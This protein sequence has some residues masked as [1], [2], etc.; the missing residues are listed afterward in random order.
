MAYQLK[1]E[2][3]ILIILDGWG[4][5][6]RYHGN[7]IKQAYTPNIDLLWHSYPTS[8]L[9]AS[10]QHVGL[11]DNQMGN[12]EVGHTT[13]GAGRTINQELVRINK[14]I[15]SG[16]FFKNHIVHQAY[17]RI[18]IH[19]LDKINKVHIIGL[20]SD[21]GVHSH[22]KHLIALLNISQG[23]KNIKTCL[24]LIT[25]GR[26]SEPQKAL[27]FLE[28]IERHIKDQPHIQICTISGR[29]YSMDRDSRWSRTKK[30]YDCLVKDISD[31]KY[32]KSIRK[33]ID[34]NYK[35]S[36]YD[37]F[38]LPT[39]IKTGSIED[40]DSIIFFNFRPDRMRQLVHSLCN[41]N[42]QEFP[43]QKLIN[44]YTVTFTK[45]DSTLELP[46]VFEKTKPQNFLGQI[47]S[48]NQLKQFR[49]A[50]TEKYA[51]VTYFFNGGQ[52]EPFPG[53]DRVMV[54]SP[55]VNIYDYTP[56]MSAQTI[57]QKLI[58][59]INKNIYSTYIVNYANP[60]M[61]GHT[62]NLLATK[63]AIEIIDKNIGQVVQET[64]K[65]NFTIIVTADHGNAEEM[66][67]SENIPCKSHSTNLVPF[68][69]INQ[70]YIKSQRNILREIGSLADI[71][72][73]ILDLLDIK[74]RQDMN[75]TTLVKSQQL[76][77]KTN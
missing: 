2:P 31:L 7:A 47:L 32:N 40:N 41:H 52:E 72:P 55:K 65:K 24:H 63:K 14:D 4:Y 43:T 62:G 35:Q 66:L 11:P 27:L 10:G 9:H 6:N 22:I 21:G 46:V 74:P 58:A 19:A 54:P 45:Y 59:A 71:A 56:E 49:L 26:D 70:K 44:L 48:E 29:Y 12:S 37:E 15:S 34:E 77:L 38:I 51:H 75:G 30:S 25:D 50:E 8:L 17:K 23:Y 61:L 13:I 67:D 36:I 73:T 39:R 33:I 16:K 28:Q 1:P 68:I 69:M 18:H 76:K 42:F 5:N 60:D 53:E 64:L 57:T 3:V 20:C